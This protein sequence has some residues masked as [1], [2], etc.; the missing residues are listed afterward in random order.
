MNEDLIIMCGK[1]H[2]PI[3]S[4]SSIYDPVTN[5]IVYNARCHGELEIA[6]LTILTIEN[7]YSIKGAVAFVPVAALEGKKDD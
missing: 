6:E 3:D 5:T 4:L 7:S 1:C 2:K